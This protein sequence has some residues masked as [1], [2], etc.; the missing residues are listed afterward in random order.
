L[1]GRLLT[2]RYGGNSLRMILL[3]CRFLPLNAIFFEKHPAVTL[4]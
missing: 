2:Q 1:H 3:I 4:R